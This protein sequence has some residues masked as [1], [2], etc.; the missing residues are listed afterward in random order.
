MWVC[1]IMSFS[2]PFSNLSF[3][4][5]FMFQ[6]ELHHRSGL[7]IPEGWGCDAEG[8]FSTDPKAV[9]SGGGLVPLGGSENTGLFLSVSNTSYSV[10]S[11]EAQLDITF[12]QQPINFDISVITA[13]NAANSDFKDVL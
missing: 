7:S 6:V 3:L 10:R 11:H 8:R 4:T 1:R 12:S 9:L 5:E 13:T 2:S